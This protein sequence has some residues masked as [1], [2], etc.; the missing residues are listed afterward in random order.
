MA[1]S[2]LGGNF[3]LAN[4]D[5][6]GGCGGDQGGTVF[7]EAGDVLLTEI[8]LSTF[9]SFSFKY[10]AICFVLNIWDWKPKAFRSANENRP[11][12]LQPRLI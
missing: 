3:D 2:G 1:G 7:G 12:L 9:F 6:A 8:T 5:F 11:L 10:L 4:V